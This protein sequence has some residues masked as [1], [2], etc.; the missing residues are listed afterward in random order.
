M[1]EFHFYLS[2]EYLTNYADN[3]DACQLSWPPIKLS[4]LI[5]IPPF[6]LTLFSFGMLK[7]NLKSTQEQWPGV[8][9]QIITCR[10]FQQIIDLEAVLYIQ[11]SR[12]FCIWNL[13]FFFLLSFILQWISVSWKHECIRIKTEMID[14]TMWEK[15]EK[16]KILDMNLFINYFVEN[17]FISKE[18]N[19]IFLSFWFNQ[20]TDLMRDRIDQSVFT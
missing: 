3:L 13:I 20:I 10:T 17:K 14:L 6:H 1:N 16:E 18:V 9:Y 8:F 2:R 15:K 4:S 19:I 7:V 5:S 12:I 11:F